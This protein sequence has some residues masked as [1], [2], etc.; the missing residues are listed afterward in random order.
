MIAPSAKKRHP[1][2]A[3]V[4]ILDVA[5]KLGLRVSGNTTACFNSK[6]HRGGKDTRPSLWLNRKRQRYCC[7]AC[8]TRGD[9][10]DLVRNVL[11]CNFKDAVE[12]L[13]HLPA[14]PP[15]SPEKDSSDWLEDIRF[16]ADV[17]VPPEVIEVYRALVAWLPAPQPRSPA[18]WY[19]QGRGIAPG[20]AES[21]GVREIVDRFRLKEQLL[22]TFGTDVVKKAGLLSV[23]GN[24]LFAH[25]PLLFI[26]YDGDAPVYIQAR[27]LDPTDPRKELKPAGRPCPVPYYANTLRAGFGEVWIC[28]GCIDTLSAL[29]LGH[30]AVGVPGA[31]AF[32]PAWV[33]LF[34]GIAD[35]RIMFDNDEAGQEAA[36]RVHRRF[37]REGIAARIFTPPAGKDINDYLVSSMKGNRYG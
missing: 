10:I 9:A 7:M 27:T 31:R 37:R 36:R 5:R 13:Q 4:D 17:S 33:K 34:R 11:D 28:E 22:T 12:F 25:H 20:L 24:L 19:L 14:R 26:Y 32:H 30:A 2:L 3:Q 16:A 21:M 23:R 1:V 18:G 15:Q 29:Q 6:G 8:D 35:V